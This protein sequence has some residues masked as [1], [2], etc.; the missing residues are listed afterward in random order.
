MLVLKEDFQ[1]RASDSDS[2]IS[3]WS[4]SASE[5]ASSPGGRPPRPRPSSVS[6]D[7]AGDGA[8]GGGGQTGA[9]GI[10][11]PCVGALRAEGDLGGV[12]GGENDGDCAGY[13]ADS[14]RAAGG[15]P[16]APVSMPKVPPPD[17]SPRRAR[18]ASMTA[19][20]RGGTTSLGSSSDG[21]GA[22]ACMSLSIRDARVS[23]LAGNRPSKGHRRQRAGARWAG[24]G[25]MGVCSMP[26]FQADEKLFHRPT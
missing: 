4:V 6:G 11:D 19:L 17:A 22:A 25:P 1:R 26:S 15:G 13:V 18:C 2:D 5:G 14:D 21:A 12:L 3:V 7:G 16:S 24:V 23:D 10:G 8:L 9:N 20:V